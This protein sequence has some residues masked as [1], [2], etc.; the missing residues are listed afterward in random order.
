MSKPTLEQIE[1]SIKPLMDIVSFAPGEWLSAYRRKVMAQAILDMWP[2][3][4]EEFRMDELDA[5]M[6]SVDKWLTGDQL[7]YNAATRAST[8]REVALKALDSQAE[9]IKELDETIATLTAQRDLYLKRHRILLY[10][11]RSLMRVLR[12]NGVDINVHG[13]IAILEG[14]E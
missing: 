10:F 5:V 13:K 4:R 6:M 14:K 1:E 9:R 12:D 8:A 3:D 7:K 11:V 2:D